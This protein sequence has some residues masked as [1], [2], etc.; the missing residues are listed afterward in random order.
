M[1]WQPMILQHRKLQEALSIM[2]PKR[3]ILEALQ[4]RPLRNDSQA[5]TGGIPGLLF[6]G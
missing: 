2:V 1:A 4:I 5:V 6:G 3:L